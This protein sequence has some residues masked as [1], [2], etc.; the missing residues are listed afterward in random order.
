MKK[1]VKEI[2][3]NLNPGKIRLL[4]PE[5]D[6]RVC[7]AK[8]SLKSLGFSIVDN[9]DYNDY[10]SDFFEFSKKLKFSKNWSDSQI[11]EYI[12]N[13]INYNMLMLQFGLADALIA[14]AST[15]TAEIARSGLRF[16]GIKKKSSCLSS[17]FLMISPNEN[18]I[19]SYADCAIVPE[20][21]EHQLADIAYDTAIN[22]N[23]LTGELPKVAFLSFS[24]NSSAN[25]YRVDKVKKAI[26]LFSKKYSDI[27]HENVEMQFDSAVCESIAKAKYSES[28]LKGS[29]NVLIYPNLDAGNIAYKITQRIGNYSA[30]GPLLQGFDKPIHDLSRG[31]DVEDI[32]DV[33]I[34]AAY[35]GSIDANL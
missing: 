5:D 19:F 2:Y 28:V 27:K 21:S 12:K 25:H 31:C 11:A 30:V 22:H 3:E 20:P 13:P 26:E 35:Q 24:T 9:Y 16:V 6:L 7:D 23:I 14:G 17:S 1:I 34:I 15:S 32:I 10:Y 18:K 33:C 8:E 29:A 4:L